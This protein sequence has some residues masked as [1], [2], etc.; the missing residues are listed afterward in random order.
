MWNSMRRAPP[1]PDPPAS[2]RVG[3]LR[4]DALAQDPEVVL[5]LRLG[6]IQ[7]NGLALDAAAAALQS[8]T[9]ARPPQHGCRKVNA[10]AALGGERPGR[11]GRRRAGSRAERPPRAREGARAGRLRLRCAG[12]AWGRG[13][14]VSRRGGRRL[15]G[16]GHLLGRGRG[17]RLEL[18]PRGPR[19]APH[20]APPPFLPLVQRPWEPGASVAQA[21]RDRPA[22]RD[23]P[24]GRLSSGL[25]G[26]MSTKMGSPFFAS[27]EGLRSPEE[28][29][30]SQQQVEERRAGS[31][32]PERPRR[33]PSCPPNPHGRSI[34]PRVLRQRPD[35][36][37]A[38]HR[39][40]HGPELPHEL[41]ELRRA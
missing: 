36:E 3:P 12:A 2:A 22:E 17:G 38:P 31:G 16:L 41:R 21:H 8:P 28:H 10:R 30:Q 39:L 35:L 15:G 37:G 34:M 14:R 1:I 4:L 25:S 9:A 27:R 20:V 11:G 33:P 7:R 26:A 13:L 40:R 32:D 29:G 19:A 6:R 5:V 18:G 24:A 23:C